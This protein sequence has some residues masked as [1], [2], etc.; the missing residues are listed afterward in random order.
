MLWLNL[1]KRYD[2]QCA[3]QELGAKIEAIPTLKVA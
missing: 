3:E 2:L 1:Q